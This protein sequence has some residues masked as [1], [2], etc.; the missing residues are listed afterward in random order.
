MRKSVT[1]TDPLLGIENQHTLQKIHR[2]VCQYGDFI[3]QCSQAILRRT[4]G[5]RSLE[6][7]GQGLA[8]ALGKR[9]DKTQGLSK[10]LVT[11]ESHTEVGGK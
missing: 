6:T 9:L 2:W 11:I 3:Q 1:G 8:F 5:V 10:N 4:V 7:V